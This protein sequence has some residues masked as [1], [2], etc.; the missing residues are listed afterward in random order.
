MRVTPAALTDRTPDLGGLTTAVYFLLTWCCSSTGVWWEALHTGA[1]ER[2][3]LP[4]W[5]STVP[6]GASLGKG[7][8]H[9]GQFI[10]G[11]SLGRTQHTPSVH[12]DSSVIWSSGRTW[13][14]G[15]LAVC[16]GGWR[17]GCL[18]FTPGV[19]LQWDPS[20]TARF[21]ALCGF[22]F[23]TIFSEEHILLI[24]LISILWYVCTLLFRRENS[25][26]PDSQKPKVFF[27]GSNTKH[28]P[29]RNRFLFM[30]YLYFAATYCSNFRF[31]PKDHITSLDSI[32]SYTGFFLKKSKRIWKF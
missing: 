2:K 13:L 17:Q 22:G 11:P 18:C 21:A 5:D 9:P 7:E 6:S 27:K 26:K 29:V 10:Q 20:I 30:T 14:Q 19:G 25:Q 12:M 32:H 16:L 3:L 31:F 8:D 23:F 4:S 28:G 24:R 1:Q 15:D